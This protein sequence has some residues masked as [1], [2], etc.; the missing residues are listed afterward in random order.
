[1]FL[2]KNKVWLCSAMQ[3]IVF[4]QTSKLNFHLVSASKLLDATQFSLVSRNFTFCPWLKVSN[5]QTLQKSCFQPENSLRR[6]GTPKERQISRVV[7]KILIGS[8]KV[9]WHLDKRD[10][11][12]SAF[13]SLQLLLWRPLFRWQSA[14]QRVLSPW[15]HRRK[16]AALEPS[17][18]RPTLVES[19]IV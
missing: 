12:I 11:W 14:P 3:I 10:F 9:L 8:T 7:V 2:N 16:L 18:R 4:G 1:M 13:Y 6:R 19:D 17:G 5:L 15:G